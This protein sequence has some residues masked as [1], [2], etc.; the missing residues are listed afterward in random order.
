MSLFRTNKRNAVNSSNLNQ[1]VSSGWWS[2]FGL[3][4]TIPSFPACTNLIDTCVTPSSQ[5]KALFGTLPYWQSERKAIFLITNPT[6]SICSSLV[7][8]STSCLYQQQVNQ[9]VASFLFGM[10]NYTPCAWFEG[11]WIISRY[12]ASGYFLNTTQNI[13]QMLPNR[14]VLASP[15]DDSY[16]IWNITI[17]ACHFNAVAGF[18]SCSPI[19]YLKAIIFFQ[20][21]MFPALSHNL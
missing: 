15:K 1:L 21:N 13:L 16:I 7:R 8:I 5:M 12:D 2:C 4:Q 20:L 10:S 14:F 6:R 3:K 11:T 17:S 19:Q 9:Q 18:E